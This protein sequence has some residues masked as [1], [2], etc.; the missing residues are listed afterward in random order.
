L[1]ALS[2]YCCVAS[3]YGV[4]SIA[5]CGAQ[6]TVIYT[7]DESPPGKTYPI[8]ASGAI[9]SD[10][11][12]NDGS[13]Y[14]CCFIAKDKR[15]VRLRF[16]LFSC[17]RCLCPTKICVA[18]FFLLQVVFELLSKTVVVELQMTTKLN[19]WRYLPPQVHGHTLVFML[20]TPVGGF[21]WMPLDDSPRPRQ[22]WKRGKDLQV[23][24]SIHICVITCDRVVLW[25]IRLLTYII[26]FDSILIPP[27]IYSRRARKL[28]HMKKVGTM[29]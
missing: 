5:I 4:G 22:V 9:I 21:H 7:H 6:K 2:S 17:L 27:S 26:S 3:R 10:E 16:Y 23:R 29:A 12:D 28:L 18:H 25:L 20:I 1:G 24:R 11:M 14:L 19:F 13:E 8:G 15:M